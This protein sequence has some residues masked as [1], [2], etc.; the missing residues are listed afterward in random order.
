MHAFHDPSLFPVSELFSLSVNGQPQPVCVFDP[1]QNEHRVDIAWVQGEPV[2]EVRIQVQESIRDYQISPRSY[3]LPAQVDEQGLCFDPQGHAVLQLQIN[4][5]PTLILLLDSSFSPRP[6]LEDP[7][8]FPVT[9][10]GV[11]SAPGQDQTEA[12]QEA[13]DQVSEQQGTLFFPPGI[14]AAKRLRPKSN[15]RIYLDS[16]A[17]IC[18][19]ADAQAYEQFQNRVGNKRAR[20][21]FIHILD[22]ENISIEG[23]GIIHAQGIRLALS[24]G[25]PEA[26]PYKHGEIENVKMSLMTIKGEGSRN[27]RIRDLL[28]M[29]STEWAITFFDCEHV[30]VRNAKVINYSD[31]FWSDGVHFTSCRHALAENCYAYCGDDAFVAT[32]RVADAPSYQVCFRKNVVGFTT[33]TG[34]RAG[35]YARDSMEDVRFEDNVIISA[36]RG[37]DLLHYGYDG[38][39]ISKILFRN[40]L[41]EE[42][43]DDGSTW[44]NRCPIYFHMARQH[45]QYADPGMVEGVLVDGLTCLN[46]GPHPSTVLS[47]GPQGYF[48]DIRFNNVVIDGQKLDRIDPELLDVNEWSKGLRFE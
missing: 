15:T 47:W 44:Q 32:T 26:R 28:V 31:W 11:Q 35:W 48:S 24:A 38:K 16:G 43:N 22:Q 29:E 40:T 23:P 18:S 13:L 45:E 4:D 10:F 25:T 20:E 7:M 27:I 19:L 36:G 12:L 46:R 5:L 17:V 34:L 8:V 6:D 1:L 30:E 41:V 33:C 39:A 2:T 14:Y 37:I 9:A 21:D 3:E 42:I